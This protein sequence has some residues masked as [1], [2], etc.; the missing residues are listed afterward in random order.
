MVNGIAMLWRAGDE[1]VWNAD[2]DQRNTEG[3]CSLLNDAVK[4]H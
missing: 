2:T 4:E 3:C 1:E